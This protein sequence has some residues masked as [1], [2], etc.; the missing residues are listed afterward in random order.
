M[1]PRSR[2]LLSFVLTLALV[3][4][5]ALAFFPPV[6]DRAA[7]WIAAR[8]LPQEKNLA[9]LPFVNIGSDPGNQPF[10]DGLL[11]VATS[12]LTQ[13][14]PAG[15]SLRV[16]PSSEVRRQPVRSAEDAYRLFNAN[17]V[18]TGSIQRNGNHVRITANLI[19]ARTKRQ[20]RS[21]MLDF[22]SK[23]RFRFRRR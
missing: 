17:L 2:G 14:S 21:Q 8:R 20:P 13:V 23:D 3:I 10:C 1:E 18:I 4:T 7:D 6:R 15:A 11:E 12:T 16:V 9:I 22:D 5:A 19:D